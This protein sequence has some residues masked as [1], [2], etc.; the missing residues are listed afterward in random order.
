MDVENRRGIREKWLWEWE[1]LRVFVGLMGLVSAL[2]ICILYPIVGSKSLF[3][4]VFVGVGLVCGVVYGIVGRKVERLG[5]FISAEG[6]DGIQSLIVNGLIQSPGI[7]FFKDDEIVLCPLVGERLT[8]RL[9][10]IVSFRQVKWF[11]GK[12]LLFKTG[13]WLS[14]PGRSR[15]GV[16][17]PDSYVELL[18]SRLR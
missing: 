8:I 12:L 3:A 16:A 4:L 15:L 9:A 18:R 11:N 10:D 1:A 7:S 13:F 2:L 17:V 14:V 6:E 5:L